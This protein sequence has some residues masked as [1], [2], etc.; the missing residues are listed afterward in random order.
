MSSGGSTPIDLSGAPVYL[1]VPAGDTLSVQGA[2]SF[3]ANLAL[4]SAGA[5]ASATSAASG[6]PA[7]DVIQGS[8]E[9]WSGG[10]IPLASDTAPTVTVDLAGNP[11][12]DRIVVSGSSIASILP[13]LR[14]YTVQADEQGTW[15]TVAKQTDAFFERMERFGF[16]AVHASA[17]RVQVSAI[18]YGGQ[19][20]G[21]LPWFWDPSEGFPT[22]APVYSVEAYAPGTGAPTRVTPTVK[23]T[24]SPTSPQVGDTETFTATVTGPAGGPTPSGSV[25]WLVNGPPGTITCTNSSPGTLIGSG[26]SASAQCLVPLDDAGLYSASVSYGGDTN[27]TSATGSGSASTPRA[28]VALSVTPSDSTPTVGGTDTFTAAVTAPSAH[29]RRPGPSPGP[30][31]A[32]RA[33]STVRTGNPPICPDP[34]APPRRPARCPFRR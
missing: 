3:G 4:A 31:P 23:V 11:V 18:D 15:T 25:T 29:P 19:L 9:G 27:Y 32:R 30:W 8:A 20:G 22:T 14:N 6:H 1:S 12:I 16:T 2:E 34:A 21:L 24:A 26:N 28:D 33:R 17:I 10:W 13:G 7:S 5:T